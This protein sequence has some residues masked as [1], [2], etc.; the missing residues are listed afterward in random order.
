ME[1]NNQ[2]F[3]YNNQVSQSV[4]SKNQLKPI[5]KNLI[6]IV[7]TAF[8]SMLIAG[9][10]I[11]AIYSQRISYLTNSYQSRI[12]NLEQQLAKYQKENG[13]NSDQLRCPADVKTC[14]D[15]TT[16]K[17]NPK[18]NCEFELCPTEISDDRRINF[19]KFGY[20]SNFDEAR[21]LHVEDWWFFLGG[22][23][24]SEV[25]YDLVFA[26]SCKFE[27]K[28]TSFAIED[29]SCAQAVNFFGNALH[30]KYTNL[31]GYESQNNIIVHKMT[32]VEKDQQEEKQEKKDQTQIE[33]VL[34]K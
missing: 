3:D 24:D 16:V 29:K 2:S 34:N 6:I 18:N 26:S 11:F 21:K 30:E 9:G 32:I 12:E 33:G 25:K 8:L 4:G 17:R 27:S 28:I 5:R 10:S 31:E 23:Y 19:S 1:K 7:I 20:L 22:M 13:E 15:G 14:G